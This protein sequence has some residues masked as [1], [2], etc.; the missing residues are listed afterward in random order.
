MDSSGKLVGC[1]GLNK[2]RYP[3]VHMFECLVIREWPHW[4]KCVTRVGFGISNSQPK[5][6]VSHFLLRADVDLSA[7]PA[8][9]L[10]TLCH[11][12]CHDDNG[13]K[14]LGCKAALIKCLFFVRVATVMVSLHSKT[15]L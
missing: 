2:K 3:E 11:A 10:L 7:P 12:P 1:V 9:G 6:S 5:A 8:P 15:G 14:P 4:K 13:T